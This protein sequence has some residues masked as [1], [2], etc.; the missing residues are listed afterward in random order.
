MSMFASESILKTD[1]EAELVFSINL[2]YIS[3]QPQGWCVPGREPAFPQLLVL[4]MI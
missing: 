2:F 4:A 1:M 3:K